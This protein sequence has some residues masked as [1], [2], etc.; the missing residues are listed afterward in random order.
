LNLVHIPSFCEPA[1]AD[2]DTERD[3]F[4]WVGRSAS[5]KNPLAFVELARQ[6][7]EARFT[8]VGI[9]PSNPDDELVTAAAR[10]PNLDLVPPLPRSAVLPFY[11]RAVAVV[12]TSDF[13]GFPNTFMEGWARGALALSLNVDPDR[14]IVRHGIGAVAGGSPTALAAAARRLWQARRQSTEERGAAVRYVTEHHAPDQVAAR[15][16]ELVTSLRRRRVPG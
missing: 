9:D 8:I 10:V 6:V 14:V 2:G 1:A 4:L 16:L 13:E 7:P 11:R 12:N 15:W 3:T 5:Y